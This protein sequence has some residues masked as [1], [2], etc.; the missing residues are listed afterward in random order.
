M[1][2]INTYFK[3]L[4]SSESN[5][6]LTSDDVQTSDTETV[7]VVDH[8]IF[9]I[10]IYVGKKLNDAEKIKYLENIWIPGGKGNQPLGQLCTEA[11]NKWKHAVERFNNHE[12]TNY[13]QNSVIDCQSVSA[14]VIGKSDSVYHQLNKAEKTQKEN[15]R[16][17]IIP[18]IDSVLICGR[19]GIALRGHRDSGVLK[20][21][22]PIINEGNFRALLRFFL[23]ATATSGDESF[24]LAR[25]NC[26]RNAQY[27]SWKI[28]NEI[29]SI[30]YEII[31]SKIVN[32]INESNF[33]SII[34]DETADISGTEQFALC[35]RYYDKKNKNIREDF[36]KFIPVH[37]VSGKS[38]A[39]HI[40]TELKK[41][42]VDVNNLRG[43]GYNGA[44]S[45]SGRFNGVAALIRNDHPSALYVHCSAHNLNLSVSSACNIQGIR[46]TMNTIETCYNFFNTPKRQQFFSTHLDKLKQNES[47][48]QKQ[49]LK[50]LC[51]ARWIERYNSIETFYEF[52]PAILN[53]LEEIIMW[54]DSDTSSKAN[55]LLLALQASEFNV[56]LTILNYIFQYTH[57]LCKY[58]Q[59]T[60]IDLVDAIEHISLVKKQLMSIR[61]N[62]SLEFNKLYNDL[63]ERLNDFEIKIEIPRLAKR[64]KH[65]INISTN[66]PEEYF[67]IALFI[68]FL[69]SYI[70]QLNDRFINHKNIISGFQM[71]MNS[72]TFNEERLKEHVEFY[73][74]SNIKTK[75]AINILNN[76]NSDLFPN[77]FKLLQILVTLPVTSCE[78]ERSFSTLKRIKTY[79]RNS[80]SESRL[81]GLAAL[82]IHYDIDVK[83]GEVSRGVLKKSKEMETKLASFRALTKNESLLELDL[84]NG[85]AKRS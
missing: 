29:V 31:S 71:L 49:K 40:I 44:V 46:N 62:V 50:R 13:H 7:S 82:N 56:A 59:T 55:Q 70:Q 79:L 65:R 72:S 41:L 67:K 77:V 24:I 75:N 53:C 69:D 48:S 2:R 42:N 28:Q 8:S 5:S 20:L 27:I 30:C 37:D 18:V 47:S 45:M 61:E 66:D 25:E 54:N 52:F 33:F 35:A 1:K 58:L 17:I 39:N 51:P 19:Q 34:A 81:N 60:N 80:T 10:N 14:I 74:D 78:A 3:V 84:K 9:D 32:R 15:N 22:D 36:L 76:C 23:K 63:N 26:A 12:K 16:K 6:K 11:F 21:E 38:L 57:S 73:N 85:I 43:Q 68:P 83:S 64:Q 4:D